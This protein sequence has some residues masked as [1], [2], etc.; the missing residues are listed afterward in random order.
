MIGR[1]AVKIRMTTTLNTIAPKSFPF[2]LV[3]AL[4]LLV[5]ALHS[6]ASSIISRNTN[7]LVTFNSSFNGIIPHCYSPEGSDTPNIQPVARKACR[8]ALAVLVKAPDFTTPFRF[9][10]NPRAMA[11]ELPAGWQSGIGATCRIVVNCLNDKDSAVF[12]FADVAQI[13]GKIID[14]CVERPDP[15]GRFPML[16]WGGI[17]GISGDDTFYVAVARPRNSVLSVEGMNVTEIMSEDQ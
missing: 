17:H 10:K 7:S 16:E 8:D 14:N 3:F 11:R 2:H 12:R 5:L 13:A 15:S 4:L 6:N 9:S 1:L